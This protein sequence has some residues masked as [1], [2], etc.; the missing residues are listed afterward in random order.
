[1]GK[2]ALLQE[3]IIDWCVQINCNLFDHILTLG[4]HLRCDFAISTE[5]MIEDDV[6]GLISGVSVAIAQG[7][8]V[9]HVIIYDDL[10]S[11]S[12][13][14]RKDLFKI[15]NKLFV[16]SSIVVN[17]NCVVPVGITKRTGCRGRI[18]GI[19]DIKLYLDGDRMR[20]IWILAPPQKSLYTVC[21]FAFNTEE[22]SL[23]TKIWIPH[24]FLLV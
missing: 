15:P 8:D 10:M 3:N 17:M 21:E 16:Y 19:S 4:K 1:M 14:N 22:W 12:R 6:D 20:N 2:V 5:D 23:K 7:S 13:L 9:F 24:R 11:Q 18:N